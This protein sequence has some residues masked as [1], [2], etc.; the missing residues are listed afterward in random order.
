MDYVKYYRER[1]DREEERFCSV[2]EE[3]KHQ[4]WSQSRQW[5]CSRQV[6]GTRRI[7]VLGK[8]SGI[9]KMSRRKG[10]ELLLLRRDLG[11]VRDQ[12]DEEVKDCREI[13]DHQ[14]ERY[15]CSFEEI[16]DREVAKN[17]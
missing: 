14:T 12:E 6:C 2:C 3:I 17:R 4:R 9:A 5:S 7:A 15:C 11:E 1:E 8:R 16:K 13:K 10:K